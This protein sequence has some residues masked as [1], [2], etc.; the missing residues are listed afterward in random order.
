VWQDELRLAGI[1]DYQSGSSK[2]SNNSQLAP[3]LLV[4]K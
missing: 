2:I 4:K 3:G 1:L